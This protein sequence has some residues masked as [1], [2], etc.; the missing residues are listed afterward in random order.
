MTRKHGRNTIVFTPKWNREY[1]GWTRKYLRAH[2]W[3]VEWMY[4]IDDL[5]QEAYLVFMHVS[6]VYPRVVD[7]PAFFA[8]YRRAITN[9][10]NDKSCYRTRR[11]HIQASLPADTADF[12]IGRIEGDAGN[13]GHV[14]A[15]LSGM[16]AD[17]QAALHHLITP[18]KSEV[19]SRKRLEPRE[20]LSMRLCREMGLPP[21]TDPISDLKKLFSD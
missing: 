7:P 6:D 19:K 14:A 18:K 11:D 5:L 20:N 21:N 4:D 15:L 12:L 9:K 2:R 3:R 13:A 16:T 1:E 10:I 8:L 17:M